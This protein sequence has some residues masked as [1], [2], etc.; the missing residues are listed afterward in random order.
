MNGKDD[1]RFRMQFAELT[2]SAEIQL[3]NQVWLRT[4]TACL[5]WPH[6]TIALSSGPIL[7]KTPAVISAWRF[8]AAPLPRNLENG[9]GNYS[10]TA[11][12]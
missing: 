2:R 12:I 8:K 9:H 11:E 7:A 3:N 6:R 5:E 4:W 10:Y 1:A